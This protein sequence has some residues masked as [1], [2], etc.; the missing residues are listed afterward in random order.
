[1]DDLLR[2]LHAEPA[3]GAA[4]N[5]VMLVL[6]LAMIGH[7]VVFAAAGSV[8]ILLLS[9]NG[10]FK[11]CRQALGKRGRNSGLLNL[12]LIWLPGAV[13]LFLSI[14]GLTLVVDD[15]EASTAGQL[16]LLLLTFELAVLAVVTADLSAPERKPASGGVL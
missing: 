5:I 15:G 11:A 14:V 10:L 16:G 4:V 9:L 12:L 13:A 1:M 6:L 3:H 7:P 2:W 8:V